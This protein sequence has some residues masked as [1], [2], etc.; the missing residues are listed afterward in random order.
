MIKTEN[1]QYHKAVWE[2]KSSK[3]IE[4][5]LRSKKHDQLWEQR[6]QFIDIRRK[7]L[8]DLL[9]K[10]EDG[11][12]VE[13]IKNQE[14]PEQVRMKMEEKLKGLK[15]TR[16]K[17]RSELVKSLQE[18]R[19]YQ[20]AD[21]LRKNDSEAFAFACYLEQE[22]QMLDKLKK[23]EQE[24]MEEQVFVKLNN[25]QNTK[26][27]EQEAIQQEEK[28]KRVTQTYDYLDWQKTQ[29]DIEMQKMAE[30]K[31]REKERL[32]EQWEKDAQNE[33]EDS[34]KTKS[35]NKLVY[36]DIEDF[37]HQEESER[38]RYNYI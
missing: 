22:N 12:R 29:Q 5:K 8:S 16:E 13:I 38:Q 35:A 15:E 24:K 18:R 6:K 14:T 26:K 34:L 3:I 25:F 28:R 4:N 21:E 32:R 20:S 2:G 33:M 9:M 10:E 1:K 11:Y 7:K 37:N 27:M 23:R 17:E 19:F 36:R 30:I 31:Q